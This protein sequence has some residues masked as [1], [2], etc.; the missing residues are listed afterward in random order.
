MEGLFDR[1]FLDKH[2]A[3]LVPMVATLSLH[4]VNHMLSRS[5]GHMTQNQTASTFPLRN[6]YKPRAVP[7]QPKYDCTKSERL[8][9]GQSQILRL[10]RARQPRPP[11]VPA[12]VVRNGRRAGCSR[13]PGLIPWSLVCNLRLCLVGSMRHSQA[14]LHKKHTSWPDPESVN[15]RAV[16]VK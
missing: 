13:Q 12:I 2:F 10:P 3:F 7:R 4:S 5:H 6:L 1:R 8:S 11:R 16:L 15:F 14:M 9:L